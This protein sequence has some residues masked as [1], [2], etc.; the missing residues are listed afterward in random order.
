MIYS[1]DFAVLSEKA[2]LPP[3][4][5]DGRADVLIFRKGNRNT[6]CPELSE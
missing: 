2:Y 5:Y 3:G 6:V 4:N 1:P